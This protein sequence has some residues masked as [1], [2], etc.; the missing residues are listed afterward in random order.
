MPFALSSTDRPFVY[1]R[2]IRFSETDAAGVV[3]FASLLSICHEAYEDAIAATSILNIKHFFSS[4][5]STAVPIVHTAAD[6]SQ[7]LFCGDSVLV[8]LAPKHLSDHAFEISYT[9]EKE[10]DAKRVRCVQALTRHVCID[11]QTRRKA[12]L[13]TEL[14]DWIERLSELE[15]QSEQD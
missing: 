8:T 3:Y 13:P 12:K 4:A 15:S 11:T 14:A 7:P 1:R 2:V 10:Q 9:I 6:F 5:A